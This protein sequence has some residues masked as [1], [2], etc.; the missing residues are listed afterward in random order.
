MNLRYKLIN[1]CSWLKG[2]MIALVKTSPKAG[3][4]QVKQFSCTIVH[5]F[6]LR[7]AEI[8]LPKFF[9]DIR[10]NLINDVCWF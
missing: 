4:P 3:K 7:Q 10:Y 9:M 8:H 5:G 2:E 6:L 1:G